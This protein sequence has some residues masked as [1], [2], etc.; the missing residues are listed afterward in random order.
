MDAVHAGT[1]RPPCF[2]ELMRKA[3]ATIS[4][5]CALAVAATNAHAQGDKPARE[6][7]LESK[8]V[9]VFGEYRTFPNWKAVSGDDPDVVEH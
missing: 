2:G 4:F 3:L 1:D 9:E 6:V 8:F 7:I 5:C